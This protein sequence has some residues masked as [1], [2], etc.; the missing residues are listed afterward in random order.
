MGAMT[1][2]SSQASPWLYGP[3]R[4]LLLGCGGGYVCV[5]VALMWVGPEVRTLLPLSLLAFVFSLVGAPH[6]GATLLRVY[7]QRRDRRAYALFAVHVTVLLALAFVLGTR[8][9]WI[10]SLM[11]TIYLS[12][13]PWHYAGQN[14]GLAVMFLRRRGIEIDPNLKRWIYAS[15]V[16]SFVIAFLVMHRAASSA[17]FA[18]L[19]YGVTDYGFLRLGIPAPIADVMIPLAV[20]AYVLS[21][22]VAGVGL[23]RR[24]SFAAIAPAVLLV[25][26]QAFWFTIP[27]GARYFSVLQGVD[28]FSGENVTY[29]FFWAA[30]AHAVQYLWVTSYYHRRDR[31][32]S[33]GYGRYFLQAL[34]AGTAL[35]IVPG[36]LF[37]PELLG[38]VPYD[39]GLATLVASTINLHHFVLDGA[40]WKLRDGRIMMQQHLVCTAA[41]STPLSRLPR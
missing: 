27:I 33:G 25:V 4:D 1:T 37:A 30:F 35:W 20:G 31:P 36:L 9:R 34:L 6:Y 19:D 39:A 28:A 8:V 17:S 14:Y 40:I 38:K 13:N 21:L 26:T 7:E 11:L 5:L 2:P 23:L 18:P 3:L 41:A 24:A 32:D 10:G 12:W 22:G 29:Y 15:F 16:L